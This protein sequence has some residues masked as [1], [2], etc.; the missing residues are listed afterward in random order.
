V[1]SYSDSNGDSHGSLATSD[2][3]PVPLPVSIFL[4]GSGLVGLVALKR[5]YLA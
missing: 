4:F 3:N 5:K 1:E 2:L